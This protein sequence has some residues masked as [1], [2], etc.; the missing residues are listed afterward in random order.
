MELG[1]TLVFPT[2]VYGKHPVLNLNFFI[3]MRCFCFF[4][5]GC[6]CVQTTP[7]SKQAFIQA[8]GLGVMK[9]VYLTKSKKSSSNYV[10][11]LFCTFLSNYYC[12]PFFIFVKLYQAFLF[13]ETNFIFIIL[14]II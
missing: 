9:K 6:A 12:C 3:H 7:A 8:F 13:I 11:I 2:Y 14:K 1:K 10:T 5:F 4:Y